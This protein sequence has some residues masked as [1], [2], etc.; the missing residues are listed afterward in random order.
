[1]IR[2]RLPPDFSAAVTE[3]DIGAAVGSFSWPGQ[4]QCVVEGLTTG[5]WTALTTIRVSLKRPKGSWKSFQEIVISKIRTRMISGLWKRA[6]VFGQILSQRD[7]ISV[8]NR[9][10]TS[11]RSFRF[12]LVIFTSWD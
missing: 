8:L 11:L 5:T 3:D 10:E 6:L 1:L 2:E 12:N 9:L 7:A 4:F